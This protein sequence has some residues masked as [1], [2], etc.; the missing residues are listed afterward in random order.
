MKIHL[1]N[2]RVLEYPDNCTKC[3]HKFEKGESGFPLPPKQFLC[4]KCFRPALSQG[5]NNVNK[6]IA[7]K[8]LDLSLEEIS[9]SFQL[10]KTENEIKK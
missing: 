3:G 10:D 1:E 2:G 9:G 6:K 8:G 4:E 7:E 5:I